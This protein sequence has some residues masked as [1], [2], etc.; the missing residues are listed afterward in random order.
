MICFADKHTRPAV[1]RMWKTC[2]N[3]SEAFMDLYFSE[4]YKDENTLIYIED[5]Q[6]VASLQILPYLFTFYGEN[7]PVSYI[8]GACTLPEFRKRG[9]MGKL[10][11]ASFEVMKQRDIPLS[12]LIPSNE[13]LYKYYK[14]FGYEKVFEKDDAEIPLKEIW[15]KSN[16]DLDLAYQ[17]FN[18]IFKNKDFCIQKTKSDFLTIIKDAKSDNFPPKTNLSGMARVIDA[19]YL[20]ALYEKHTHTPHHCGLDPQSTDRTIC[21]LLFEQQQPVLNLMLE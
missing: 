21:R 5:N 18:Q 9:I 15:E 20:I 11:I 19:E 1:R 16:G 2:F 17:T 10:L 13:N 4:K 6:A 7:I 14:K 8:S 12:I 3:D